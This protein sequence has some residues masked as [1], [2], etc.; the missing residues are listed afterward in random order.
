MKQLINAI[1]TLILRFR[2]SITFKGL[3]TIKPNHRPILFLPN[4]PALID[5]VILMNRLYN[6]FKPRPL[7]EENHANHQLIRPFM[8]VVRAV[9]IPDMNRQNRNQRQRVLTGINNIV[10]GL[11]Q[12]DNIL[13]YPAGRLSRN[14]REELG[15]KSGVET[16]IKEVKD[17]RIVLVRTKG[18]WG[19]SFSYADHTPATGKDT[20]RNLLRLLANCLFF[21]PRRRVDIEL[22]EPKDFPRQG[23]RKILNTYLENYYNSTRSSL[24]RV[25]YFH[26]QKKTVEPQPLPQ[27]T[28]INRNTDRVPN[29]IRKDVTHKVTDL[30]GIETIGDNDKLAQDL[31][32]DSLALLEFGGWLQKQYNVSPE[33]LESLQTVADCMLAASGVITGEYSQPLKPI[34]KTWFTEQSQEN[35]S[36][37]QEE[38]IA[39]CFLQQ[40]ANNPDQ[41]IISDQIAG[42]KTYRQLIMAIIALMPDIRKINNNR[43]GIMLPASVGAAISYLTVQ[44]GGK[45]A[46]QINWTTGIS[47]MS[48]CLNSTGVHHIISARA[49]TQR[50]QDQGLDLDQLDV[51]WLYLEDI[52]AKMSK[53]RKIYALLN[54]YLSWRL[55]KKARIDTTAVILFTSGSEAMP[56]SVPLSH[57]NILANGQDTAKILSLK[58]DDKL[59]GILPPFHSLGLSGTIIM[60]LCIGLKTAYYPNPTEGARVAQ[61]ISS[62]QASVLLS[63]PTFLNATLHSSS[64]DHLKSL[65]LVFSGAEKCPEHLHSSL[66]KLCPKTILCEGY[67]VTECSPV[68]SVNY[69]DNPKPGTI[70]RV[71]PSM[72]YRLIHPETHES[73][74]PG[75][76][77]LLIVRGPNVFSGYLGNGKSPFVSFTGKKWYDTG[78]LV[79]EQDSILTF[80]GRLKRFIKLG[81]EMISLPAI[82]QVMENAFPTEKGPSLAVTATNDE[83]HPALVLFTVDSINRERANK[84]IRLAGLSGLHTI[85]Q[86]IS[87]D[88][89]PLLGSGKTDYKQLDTFVTTN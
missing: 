28:T 1:V 62:Y 11:K 45:V 83:E 54:S 50:L 34:N 70:G 8:K 10:D 84:A 44:F 88:E 18:L 7:A 87:I 15:A 31:G 14:G 72:D 38:T 76:P 32:M 56:K 26:F 79:I 39:A 24:I 4:H 51:K 86:V 5:P 43:I 13:L 49:L 17:V 9:I 20:I 47:Q 3:D 68:I 36:F 46:V 6:T 75:E 67:G 60:P 2:Y 33:N 71:L 29:Q 69:P 78:D 30:A 40:A 41:A 74:N 48:H 25:P 12:G 27:K 82:E 59:L 61:M 64:P 80:S 63:T 22:H 55:L 53:K 42:V 19:S 58:S 85:R 66:K 35:L 81:G 57:A 77:G 89:I 37:P 23:D 21:M 73:V 52:A 65:R 16:I